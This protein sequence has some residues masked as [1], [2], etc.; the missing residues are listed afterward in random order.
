MRL[1]P[2]PYRDVVAHTPSRKGPMLGDPGTMTAIWQGWM[3]K[4][5]QALSNLASK[6]GTVS[7][8]AQSAAIGP[9]AIATSGLATARYRVNYTMR[10]TRPAS[11]MS[12]LGLT[13]TWIDGGVSCS[14]SG[15]TITGNTTATQQ[16]GTWVVSVDAGSSMTYATTYTSVGATTMQYALYL[17][18]E[19]LP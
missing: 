6:V 15:A 2:P 1:D 14:Q 12:A 9:T 7:L 3:A 17:V 8:T 16:N 18:L 13:V 5:W 4:L 10:V 19:A 11:T